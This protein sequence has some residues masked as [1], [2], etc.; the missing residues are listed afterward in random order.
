MLIWG[1]L[2][3]TPPLR[4]K[5][6]AK[7]VKKSPGRSLTRGLG[8]GAQLLEMEGSPRGKYEIR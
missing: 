3:L 7:T 6:T 4:Q 2:Q 1:T 8:L 5:C